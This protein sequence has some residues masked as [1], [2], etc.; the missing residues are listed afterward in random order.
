MD[1]NFS[2]LTL[3]ESNKYE[4]KTDNLK[5]IVSF[6]KYVFMVNMCLIKRQIVSGIIKNFSLKEQTLPLYYFCNL[7]CFSEKFSL[8]FSCNIKQT[9]RVWYRLF[10][11]LNAGEFTLGPIPKFSTFR[12]RAAHF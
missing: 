7:G 10:N 4:L 12:L 1:M 3:L 2:F 9:R 5:S 11:K 6:Q 8:C